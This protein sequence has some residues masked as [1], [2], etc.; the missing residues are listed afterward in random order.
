[1]YY[2]LYFCVCIKNYIINLK[3]ISM[4]HI[5]KNMFTQKDTY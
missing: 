4:I 5:F 3:T 2:G 1:M